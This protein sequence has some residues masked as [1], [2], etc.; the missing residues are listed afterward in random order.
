M[1]IRPRVF[2]V[3]RQPS[4]AFPVDDSRQSVIVIDKDIGGQVVVCE[5]KPVRLREHF[6]PKR[7][8]VRALVQ[9][10][11]CIEGLI[12]VVFRRERTDVV[13]VDA[14]APKRTSTG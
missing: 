7:F 2:L 1:P 3:L 9:I 10:Y 11:M 5:E 8:E 14:K 13:K 12:Q 6:M 4:N